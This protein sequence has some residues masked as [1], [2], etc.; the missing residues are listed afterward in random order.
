MNTVHTHIEEAR[1]CAL[2][3]LK[4]NVKDLEHGLELHR[5]AVVVETYGFGPWGDDPERVLKAIRAGAVG[6][7]LKDVREE[8]LLT[9]YV[10]NPTQWKDYQAMWKASGVTCLFRNA[11]EEG[12]DPLNML[13]RFSHFLYVTDQCRDFMPKALVSEDVRQ[14]K[15][16]GRHCIYAEATRSMTT[17]KASPDFTACGG[18]T[19]PQAMET[20]GAEPFSIPSTRLNSLSGNRT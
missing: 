10:R 18:N 15:R 19:I 13:R 12:Q 8:V 4:P 3:I 6:T 17:S 20:S 1:Q 2:D 5:Q 14:A 7:Q 11:G 16:E 9:S